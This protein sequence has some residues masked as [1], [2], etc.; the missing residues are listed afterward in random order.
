MKFDES[1]VCHYLYGYQPM[2]LATVEE[3][4]K[5]IEVIHIGVC[6]NNFAFKVELD[7]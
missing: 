5:G 4:N 3:I 2:R 6:S 7:Y 1:T